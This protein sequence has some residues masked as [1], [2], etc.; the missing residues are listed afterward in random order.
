MDEKVKVSKQAEE[1]LRQKLEELEVLDA[2]SEEAKNAADVVAKQTDAVVKLKQEERN[3]KDWIWKG[4]TILG[5][6]ATA[7]VAA[8]IKCICD[9]KI[10][11]KQ[12]DYLSYEHDRAY[13]HEMG[14]EIE[15]LVRSPAAKEALKERPK[16]LK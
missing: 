10:A 4:L 11:D 3:K 2:S 7:A 1:V 15:Q 5:G 16:G 12:L 14:A 6:V 13:Q 9:T 8:V